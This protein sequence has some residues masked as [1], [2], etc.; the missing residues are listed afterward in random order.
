MTKPRSSSAARLSSHN[1][2]VFFPDPSNSPPLPFLVQRGG[3]LVWLLPFSSPLFSFMTRL[4]EE[5]RERERE[6]V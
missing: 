6:E 5:E 3:A 4:W 1:P 2:T